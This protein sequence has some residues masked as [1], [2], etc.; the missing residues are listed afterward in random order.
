M[1]ENNFHTPKLNN[2]SQLRHILSQSVDELILQVCVPE[3]QADNFTQ[4]DGVVGSGAWIN[5]CGVCVG[6]T[7]GLAQH[8]GR[9]YSM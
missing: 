3:N 1:Y 9:V 5:D 2:I 7:T 6:G 4:C 8:T